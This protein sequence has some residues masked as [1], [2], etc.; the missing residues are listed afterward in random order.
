MKKFNAVVLDRELEKTLRFIASLGVA[1]FIDI[2]HRSEELDVKLEPVEASDRYYRI[3]NLLTR[4]TALISDMGVVRGGS[5]KQPKEV[6][7]APKDSYLASL[8]KDLKREEDA[9]ADLTRS[10]E[11]AQEADD[12]SARKKAEKAIKKR[13]S[14]KRLLYFAW[15]E[16]LQREHHFE[17][18]K[19]LFG[20]TK[21]TYIMAGWVPAKQAKDFKEAV[22]KHCGK[23]VALE[24]GD[25]HEPHHGHGEEE[26]PVDR[27]PTKLKNSRFIRSFEI[28][29][30]AFGMPSHKEIDPSLFMAIGFPIIFG[31]MFG[32]IGHGLL[33][34][35][36]SGLGFLA[37]KKGVDA[38]EMVNYFVQGSGMLMVCSVSAIFFGILYGEFLG[39]DIIHHSV[40]IGL[41][42]SPFAMVMRGGLLALFRFFDF[43]GGVNWF[44]HPESPGSDAYLAD[45]GYGPIWFSAFESPANLPYNVASPTWVLF[46]LSIIIGFIHLSIAIIM[47]L[48]NKVRQR[49]WKHA[50]FGPGIWLWFFWGLAVLL[51]TKGINFMEWFSYNDPSGLQ[52]N[53]LGSGIIDALVFL[54]LPLIIMI[55]GGMLAAGVMEGFMEALEHLIASISNTISYARILALNMAHAGFAKTFLFI[56]GVAHTEILHIIDDLTTG[57]LSM[58]MFIIMLL[59]G[60]IFVLFMEGL[61]SF[62]HTLRLHWVEAYLKFYA[63]TGYAFEPLS[64][65]SKWTV[66]I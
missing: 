37:K 25:Y 30:S 26:E 4:V 16:L 10:L 59:V 63:G 35:F 39:I 46:V 17:E 56:G 47:D 64:V 53:I 2:Q 36:F 14:E 38:G 19:T 18:T 44:I 15:E 51:F 22:Q 66:I 27:P 33:L 24:L 45:H 9:F 6:P 32:D 62:I 34:L 11:A 29:T 58:M 31:L 55:V 42:S 54:I 28:L 1:H 13:A 23:S 8:E 43:D 7:E 41:R 60:T 12:K 40:Y 52:P 49:E 5:T 61:L 21:R 65:P 48:V 3:S 50:I 57:Q 20:K